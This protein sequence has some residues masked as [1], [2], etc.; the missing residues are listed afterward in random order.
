MLALA[1]SC[2]TLTPKVSLCSPFELYL[3]VACTS[4]VFG[5]EEG[6][7]Q[8]AET[9]FETFNCGPYRKVLTDRPEWA[10]A[11]AQE[12][13][14]LLPP[15]KSAEFFRWLNIEKLSLVGDPFSNEDEVKEKTRLVS[16]MKKVGI[17]TCGDFLNLPVSSVHQRFG[18]LGETLHDWASGRRQLCLPI[19]QSEE[20]LCEHLDA[21]ELHSFD[22]LL[23]S[24]RQTLIRLQIRLQGR[25]RAGK[26]IRLT[27]N[28]ESHP[29]VTKMLDLNEGTQEAQVLLRVL[30]EFLAGFKWESPLVRLEMEMLDLI[31][32]QAGQLSLLDD[33]EN[34]FADL[35]QY[36]ARL[37]ARFGEDHAGFATLQNSHLP[38][39][40]SKLKW[41]PSPDPNPRED[42]PLR[43]LFLYSEP[44]PFS[45]TSQW[46]LIHS[47]NLHVEWWNAGGQREYFIARNQ[48][49]CL[50]VY[51]DSVTRNWFIHGNFN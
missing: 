14:V 11:L 23:F 29:A 24:L 45:P 30:K 27:F 37:R 16:F 48:T 26:K 21:D 39:H 7:L 5:G 2:F 32:H 4:N 47:E 42:F 13:D 46:D 51:R 33:S 18:K 36:V 3:E 50:W 38:E 35:A 25:A 34:R 43:P 15:G 22:A 28:F 6:L 49:Q 12:T 1:E 9:L 8:K 19:F 20:P 17:R 41:P 10:K 44:K 31:P 40:T